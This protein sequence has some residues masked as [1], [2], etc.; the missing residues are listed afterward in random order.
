LV[1]SARKN[2]IELRQTYERVGKKVLRSQSGY[3]KAN[4]FKRARKATKQLKTYLGRIVRDIER[5]VAHPAPELAE[6][7]RQGHRFLTQKKT[8]KQKLYSVHE[9]QVEC[10]QAER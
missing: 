1:K 5:K 3:A 2:G 6:L 10:L 8:D 7:L 9:P 4:Q